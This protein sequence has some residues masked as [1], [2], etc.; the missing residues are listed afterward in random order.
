[1]GLLRGGGTTVIVIVIFL[2]LLLSNSLLAVTMSLDY[3]TLEPELVGVATEIITEQ[4]IDAQIV[5]E[6]PTMQQDC[7]NSSNFVFDNEGM[8]FDIPCSVVDQGETAVI[9]F[10]ITNMVKDGYYKEYDCDFWNCSTG[11][12]VP[13][14]LF[15]QM[16]RDYW[17]GK[18]YLVLT[19]ILILTALGFLLTEGRKNYP[20][21]IG[22]IAILSALPF[23]KVSWFFSLFGNFETARMLG[24]FF[25]RAFSVFM[26]MTVIGV[27]L[28]LLGVAIKFVGLG[29]FIDKLMGG[30]K[31]RMKGEVKEEIKKEMKEEKK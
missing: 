28:I 11:E 17:K 8:V 29:S 5:E 26:I 23:I 14:H 13:A 21:L 7:L 20:F 27:V 18:F 22:G 25:S 30:D 24:V 3:Q 31:K 15:S 16:A 1:M 19:G 2:L 4:G 10:A 6:L 9:E 12:D